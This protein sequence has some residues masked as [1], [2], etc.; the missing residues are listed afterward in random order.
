[1]SDIDPMAAMHRANQ[2]FHAQV[3]QTAALE[4]GTAYFSAEF[5]ALA[6]QVRDVAL[7]EGWSAAQAFEHVRDFFGRLEHPC[8]MWS[9]SPA[10]SPEPF[11]AFL[12]THDYKAARRAVYALRP[13]PELPE[14]PEVRVVPGRAVKAALA[15]CALDDP[16]RGAPDRRRIS[17]EALLARFDDPQFEVLVAMHDRQAAGHVCLLQVGP[18]AAIYDLYVGEPFRRRGIARALLQDLINA[19]RRL[20]LRTVVLEVSEPNS[21]AISLYERYGFERVGTNVD[22]MPA[23]TST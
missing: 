1:M 9:L 5:G 16:G 18:V 20:E 4:C 21:A 14:R 8:R 22:F 15:D 6:N 2:A 23:R 7:P 11:E 10:Q 3:A 19:C 17:T 13:W 12:S